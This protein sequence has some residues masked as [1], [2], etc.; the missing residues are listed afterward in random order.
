MPF[1]GLATNGDFTVASGTKTINYSTN[2]VG[3]AIPFRHPQAPGVSRNAA[4]T[5]RDTAQ[6]HTWRDYA[7]LTG[8]NRNVNG[9]PAL[10]ADSWLYGDANGAT[11]VVRIEAID[12]GST[13]TIKLWLDAIFGRFGRDYGF[14][15]RQLDMLTWAP[16]IPSWYTGGTTAADV[17]D[18]VSVTAAENLAVSTDGATAYINIRCT[19]PTIVKNVYPETAEIYTNTTDFPTGDSLVGVV[20]V[21]ISGNGDLTAHGNGI[22]GTL[23]EDMKFETGGTPIVSARANFTLQDSGTENWSFTNDNPNQPDPPS[24][25]PEGSDTFTFIQTWSLSNAGDTSGYIGRSEQSHTATLYK[26]PDGVVTREYLDQ[27]TNQEWSLAWTNSYSETYDCINQFIVNEL[28]FNYG[29]AFYD[30]WYID[31]CYCSG[32]T[33]TT[34][35][36]KTTARKTHAY[37]V[38][39]DEYRYEYEYVLTEVFNT[40]PSLPNNNYMEKVCGA[41]GCQPNAP[42]NPADVTTYTLNGSTISGATDLWHE[43]RLLAPN[44]HYLCLDYPQTTVTTR[45]MREVVVGI[46]EDGDTHEEYNA[47]TTHAILGTP[48][49][50]PDARELV[51]TWQPVLEVSTHDGL[52]LF[53]AYTGDYYQYC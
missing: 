9:G 2:V 17:I 34:R 42:S 40:V 30:N 5:T 46:D 4:Q 19:D 43:Y 49:K 20:A 8:D 39:G 36:N 38:F 3:Q 50:V 52:T 26:H 51:W 29:T 23:V 32:N 7:L 10:G 15:A 53:T 1:H 44:L 31:D 45:E 33:Y 12:N 25:P 18:N 24:G 6:G 22:T 35:T 37:T 28:L 13:M 21:T 11:W 14:A 27:T 41:S 47:V 48:R 16:E